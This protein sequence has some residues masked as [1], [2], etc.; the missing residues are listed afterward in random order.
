M[1]DP[2]CLDELLNHPETSYC[3]VSPLMI[4]LQIDVHVFPAYKMLAS[5]CSFLL[6]ADLA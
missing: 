6:N 2:P 5:N 3:L 4:P 1:L